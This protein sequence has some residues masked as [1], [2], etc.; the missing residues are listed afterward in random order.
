MPSTTANGSVASVASVPITNAVRT[1][2]SAWYSTSL[3][4]RSVP[5]TW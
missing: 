3:P 5:S 1:L 4:V 2:F